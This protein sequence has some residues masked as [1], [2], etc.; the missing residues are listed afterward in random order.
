MTLL[1]VA[2]ADGCEYQLTGTVHNLSIRQ[3]FDE[4]QPN[5][6]GAPLASITPLEVDGF[7]G[8]T[9]SGGSCNAPQIALVPHCNGTHTECVGH[10]TGDR[11]AVDELCPALP[12]PAQLISID[13]QGQQ[14]ISLPMLQQAWTSTIASA[15]IIRT[16]PNGDEQ[17]RRLYEAHNTPYFNRAALEFIT[18]QNIDHLLVDLPSIDAYHDDGHLAAHRVFFGLPE[19]AQQAE[20]NSAHSTRA[21]ATLTELIYV[22]DVVLDGLYLLNLQVAPFAID[23]A[24]S[25]PLLWEIA[26]K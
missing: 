7:V 10:L 11:I 17:Q 21:H 3:F 18:A 2:L 4:N 13:L 22:P 6:F 14:E 15:L 1:N 16:L 8:D 19:F 20:V 24:P 26:S 5:H 9:R 25:R 23:G 12:L